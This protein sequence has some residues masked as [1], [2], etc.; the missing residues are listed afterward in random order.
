MPLMPLAC[1]GAR[2]D[3]ITRSANRGAW[4]ISAHAHWHSTRLYVICAEGFALQCFSLG[5][6]VCVCLSVKSHLTYGASVR[7]ENAVTHSTGNEGQKICGGLPETTAFKSYAAKHERKSQLFR[8][9]R[10][11]LSPLDTQ[12]RAIGYPTIV[13][14]IQPCP[15]L[16]LLMQIAR[17][18]ARTDSTTRYSYNARRGQLPRTRIGVVRGT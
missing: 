4:P 7:P 3:S 16:C 18:V 13:N 15:Q 9:T 11:Q 6:C 1:V 14:N 17:V 10:C 2:S 8:L 12:R 5:L